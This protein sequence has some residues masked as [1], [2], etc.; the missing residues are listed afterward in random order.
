MPNP[1]T[2]ESSAPRSLATAGLPRRVRRVLEQALALVSEDLDGNLGLMLSE[3]EQELFRLADQARNPGTESGYMQTLRTFRLN[4]SDL[5]PHFMLELE[6]SVAGIRSAPASAMPVANEPGTGAAPAPG[7]GKLSLVDEAVMDEGTVLREIASRQEGRANLPLHLLGQRFGVLAA[8]PAF[9]AERI[10]LGPQSL[11]RAMRAA[12][13]ALRIE[14]DS[15]LLLYRI[16]DRQVMATYSRILERLDELLD[17]EGILPGL[18]YV[19]MRTRA[20]PVEADDEQEEGASEDADGAQRP[21]RGSRPAPGASGGAGHPGRAEEGGQVHAGARDRGPGGGRGTWAPGQRPHTAW[22]GEPPEPLAEDENAA[23]DKLLQL[24]SGRREV[25]GKLR[26]GK[27]VAPQDQMSTSE[28]FHALGHLQSQPLA[29]PGAPQTLADVRQTLLAQARQRKGTGADLSPQDSDTFELLDMLYTHLEEEIRVDAPAAALVRR[30]Q[31]PLLRVAL[32]DR[33]FFVRNHH[34]ARQLLNT[35]AE[36]AARWLDDNDFDPHFL[37]P[38]QKAVTD[39]VEKYD[40]D[41]EVF[42]SSNEQLQTHLQ[43][44]VRKAEMLERRH[45]EAARGKEKL[46]VA[47]LRAAEMMNAAIGE[48]RLP[49]FTRALLNQAWAD[50]LT[51]TLL[52]QGE[53]SDA[54]RKQLDVTRQIVETCT[55]DEAANDPALTAHVESSLAQVGY[56]AEEAAVIAQRLTSSAPENED[57]P[58]SRTEL[59]MKLKARTRLG[60]DAKAKKPKLSPRTPEEQARY[61]QLRVL[62]FGTWIE[63]ITNQQGDVVRRRLSWF[64]PIT[65]NALFVNQRGQRVGEHSLDAVARMLANGQARIV[66]ADRARLVDRAWQA[67]VSALRS[68][69]GVG[70]AGGEP[71]GAKP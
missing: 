42:A 10:P 54:W 45:T 62:P 65:D 48:Q 17:R 67:A 28:I 56:H 55:R 12:S 43:A 15:R 47:K 64:S 21:R 68:F 13:Q 46:E 49:K 8:T 60:E 23:I 6:A 50:V 36:S 39:V 22:M 61:E 37:A 2:T 34:P 69:A 32:Q 53:D 58:A 66:T 25:L 51:L 24:L 71:A 41:T 26:P 19:P 3:F 1:P 27:A 4:R 44:Q 18:T 9:D 70:D 30:L 38:L 40:G 5:V 59:A 57:D 16:F 7:F 63:F 35:V 14:H 52:R 11:C 20:K 31:V 33:A 29:T